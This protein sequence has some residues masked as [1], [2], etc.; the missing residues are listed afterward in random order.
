MN[1][2]EQ[3]NN[4]D[5]NKPIKIYTEDP[6]RQAVVCVD[7]AEAILIKYKSRDLKK[8]ESGFFL[9]CKLDLEQEDATD[10]FLGTMYHACVKKSFNLP[11]E[12]L[13]YIGKLFDDTIV[14]TIDY[15]NKLSEPACNIIKNWNMAKFVQ[16]QPVSIDFMRDFERQLYLL[17]SNYDFAVLR[18]TEDDLVQDIAVTSEIITATSLFSPFIGMRSKGLTL[19]GLISEGQKSSEYLS[20]KSAVI[21]PE[22]RYD[23]AHEFLAENYLSIYDVMIETR[24]YLRF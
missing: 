2:P 14:A 24:R 10:V 19:R 22:H 7:W 4:S 1:I 9:P 17:A 3:N 5:K 20:S 11:H 16:K 13:T 18:Y 15:L 23:K 6:D 21:D 8:G 12:V